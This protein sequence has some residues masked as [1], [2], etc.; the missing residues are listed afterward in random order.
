MERVIVTLSRPGEGKELDLEVPLD[1]PIGTLIQEV[2]LA[3]G[4]DSRNVMYADP[5]GRV[6]QPYETLAQAG[7]WDGARLLFQEQASYT[8][9]PP[10]PPLP[11]SAP[12][13]GGEGP[14]RGW[15]PLDP[16]QPPAPSPPPVPDAPPSSS[17]G[18]FVWRQVDQD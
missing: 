9:G 16:G 3:L 4:W 11:S 2:A 5:P 15:R 6:L 14:V 1:I 18:G 17:P 8:G 10:P 7:V 12:S 13:S